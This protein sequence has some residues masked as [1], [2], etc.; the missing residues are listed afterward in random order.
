[1]IRNAREL[2]PKEKQAIEGLLGRSISD[3]QEI[4]IRA[5]EAH[6]GVTPERRTSSAND[7]SNNITCRAYRSCSPATS[8]LIL[9]PPRWLDA[10]GPP[11]GA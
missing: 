10:P 11:C 7:I 4:S 2:S 3:E 5:L 1:M 6:K 8:P 9:W